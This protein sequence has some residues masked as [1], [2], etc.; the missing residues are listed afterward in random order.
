MA[1]MDCVVG[2]D[3]YIWGELLIHLLPF[4]LIPRLVQVQF[5]L[6]SRAPFC[7][8][9]LVKNERRCKRNSSKDVRRLQFP[10]PP[11]GLWCLVLSAAGKKHAL[12]YPWKLREF[13]Y[14]ILSKLL[15]SWVRP[16][17]RR[18]LCSFSHVRKGI[19]CQR[20]WAHLR[21]NFCK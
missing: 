11:D 16:L 12:A 15:C 9:A 1:V 18:F 6:L 5:W 14:T 17:S 7:W 3:Q 10:I 13:H 19:W 4:Q 2:T 20:L 8:F 21:G